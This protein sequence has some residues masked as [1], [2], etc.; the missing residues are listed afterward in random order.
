MLRNSF[1]GLSSPVTA[2]SSGRNW[3]TEL[4]HFHCADKDLPFYRAQSSG[5]SS[6]SLKTM[7][8]AAEYGVLG[9]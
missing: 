5:R 2:R 4:F 9:A 1:R 6:M 3:L 7:Q 8:L